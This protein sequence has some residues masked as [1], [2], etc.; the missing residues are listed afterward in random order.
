MAPLERGDTMR[1]LGIQDKQRF[2]VSVHDEDDE[3]SD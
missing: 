2:V 3:E 1:S